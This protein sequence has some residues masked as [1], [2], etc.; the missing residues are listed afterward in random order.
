[1]FSGRPKKIERGLQMSYKINL[2]R[3]KCTSWNVSV[4]Y[5]HDTLKNF[6][7]WFINNS[8]VMGRGKTLSEIEKERIEAFRKANYSR[9]RIA[10][11]LNRSI[12]VFLII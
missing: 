2:T 1:M 6:L 7:F 8:L 3:C 4:V 5:K 11:Q 10:K 9:L 12:N